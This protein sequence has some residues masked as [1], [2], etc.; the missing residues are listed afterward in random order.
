MFK[1]AYGFFFSF[2][3]VNAFAQSLLPLWYFT[4]GAHF[5]ELLMF[6]VVMYG[7]S[8][9]MIF[10]L[11]KITLESRLTL[12]IGL[13]LNAFATLVSAHFISPLQIY[14]S[15]FLIGVGIPFFWITYNAMHF[16]FGNR[17]RDGFSSGAYFLLGPLLGVLSAPFAGV[18]A[19]NLN[20]TVFFLIGVALYSIPIAHAYFLPS[21]QMS[22]DARH[23]LKQL[24][25]HWVTILQGVASRMTII[26]IPVFT[27]TYIQEPAAFGNFFG[28]LSVMAAVAALIN[29]YLSDHFKNRS[30]FFY[31]PTIAVVISF[32]PLALADNF[33]TWGLWS[34]IAGLTMSLASPF[35]LVYNIDYYKDIST[36]KV[37]VLRE[38]YLHIGYIGG[39]LI[40]FTVFI[41]S[42]S[43]QMAIG[44]VAGISLLLPLVAYITK[45]YRS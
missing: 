5:T 43:I 15:G 18:L 44:G 2:L 40:A 42:G 19:E 3:F 22:F 23:E 20:Y 4:N 35:W 26:L 12:A 38:V 10:L 29:G 30:F 1:R 17:E 33:I 32:I 24:P 27:I 6:Y 21:F 28:Y 39:L 16:K 41:L 36:E 8:F 11:Q 13:I 9:V 7:A 31:G 14:L 45:V 37:M 34:G 25:I